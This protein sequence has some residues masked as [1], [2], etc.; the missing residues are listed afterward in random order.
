MP[1]NILV[2]AYFYPAGNN[3]WD[4][5]N[6]LAITGNSVT[7]I[8]NP[9]NGP[10]TTV[11]S[12]YTTA[13]NNLLNAGGNAIGYVFSSYGNRD[14]AAVKADI[15]TYIS[16]YPSVSGFF[17]DEM[18]T[19]ENK[20]AYYQELHDYIKSIKSTFTIVANPGTN[21]LESYAATADI[22]IT[23]E[24]SNNNYQT[25]SAAP[26]MSSYSPSRFAHL[27]YGVSSA[28]EF[29]NTEQRAVT[30]GAGNLYATDDNYVPGS[31]TVVNPWDILSSYYLDN[32]ISGTI[33]N[34]VINGFSGNDMLYGYGGSDDIIGGI[35]ND[36]LD[37]GDGDDTLKGLDGDDQLYGR[38]GNDSLY[39]GLGNDTMDGGDG[40][41]TYVVNTTTD[42]ILADTSG[43]DTVLVNYASG[44]YTL[45]TANDLENITLGGTAAINGTGNALDNTITGNTA[46]NTLYGYQGNDTLKGLDGDDIIYGG[47]GND[48]LFGGLGNDTMTGGAGDDTYVVNVSTDVILADTSGNDTVLV[49]YASGTYTLAS[50][51]DNI[52]LGGAAAINAVGNALENFIIGNSG[53]NILYG[54]GQSDVLTGGAGADT[55]DFNFITDSAA[56]ITADRITDFSQLEL[57]K[58]DFSTIDADTSLANDQAFT[59]IGND[60]AFGGVA[61]ELRFNTA[62]KTIYGDI[63]GDSIADFQVILVGAV[64]PMQVNDFIL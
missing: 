1:L 28:N 51:L 29:T 41:D 10:K 19:Q 37:G 53:N 52:T 23:F 18:S 45:S 59:F 48:T 40:D 9:N 33:L 13:I 31:S 44:T 60:V 20:L 26:W 5:L 32:Q 3:Y 38:Q 63:D 34:D 27:V 36:F 47:L 22:L 21:T 42:V 54:G 11:D 56:D 61:G 16:Q 7:A 14:I 25:Y 58:I 6:N 17:I 24:G 39:G 35:G 8:F 50:D 43:N 30:I 49:N 12:N 2:P 4:D 15:T 62:N 57:D 64:N 46:S 55:F